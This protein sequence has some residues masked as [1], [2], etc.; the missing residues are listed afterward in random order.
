MQEK[1]KNLLKEAVKKAFNKEI[2]DIKVEYPAEEIHGDY[3]SNV[4]MHLAKE[5][6]KNPQ[7]IAEKIIERRNRK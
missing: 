7:E 3:A 1:I 5:L 2:E 4:A 6:N